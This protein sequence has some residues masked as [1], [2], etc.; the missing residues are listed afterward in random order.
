MMSYGTAASGAKRSFGETTIT[1]E[2]KAW[3]AS[4][5]CRKAKELG[6][7]HELW[8]TRLLARHARE[9]GT[10]VLL[11]PA[12]RNGWLTNVRS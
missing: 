5:S 6:Y 9:H 11:S 3:L 4:L 10:A 1:L 12:S 7:P 8:T 2:A